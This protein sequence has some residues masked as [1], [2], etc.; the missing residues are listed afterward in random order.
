MASVLEGIKVLDF[1]QVY[2]GPFC[3]LMLKD[4]GADI[5]KVER[6]G[7]GDLT[8]NDF[9]HTEGLEGGAYIILNRGK[10]SVT[11]DLKSEKGRAIIKELIK[12]VDVLVENFSPGTM[13]KLGLGSEEIC[14]ANPSLIYASISAYGQTGP[15]RDYPGFDPVAQAMGGM[16]A[17][18][19]FPEQP[20]RSG[21]SIADFTSGLFTATSILGA[22]I[23]RMKTGE[24]QTIDISMQQS[25]WQLASIEFS[26]YYFLAGQ[27]PPRLGNGHAA[28]IPCNVYPTTD[29]G[30][31]IA[32]GVLDQVKRLYT[33]IGREDLIDTPLCANQSERIKHRDEINEIISAW[34]KNMSTDDVMKTLQAVDV[35]CS[36]VPAFSEVCNDP[37]LISRNA[38][39]E[40]EQ[41]I[42][43]KVKVPG[44]LFKMSR[45]PGK[46]DYPAPFL[47][48][49]NQDILADLLG[50]TDEEIGKL[51]DEGII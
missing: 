13:D 40:V 16:T 38:I 31:F 18:T 8:R 30:L 27:E 10:K 37:Q 47:G 39:I 2:S 32:A 7:S 5:I 20:V 43:G 4:L 15:Y 25:I 46:I 21:V 11:I 29:G 12:K 24:G 17:V 9:P 6:P 41:L 44:S 22:I 48:E 45:T 1:T 34:T 49:N 19:G 51:S 36:R 14:E 28:M 42:S 23:H 26:P 50:Y 33:A 3:T 35:P